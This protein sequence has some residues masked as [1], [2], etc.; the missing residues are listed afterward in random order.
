M[1]TGI[2]DAHNLAWKLAAVLHSNA[3]SPLLSTYHSERKPVAQ[4]NAALSINNWLEAVRVPKALGLDPQAAGLV[5]QLASAAPLPQ[6][7]G[8]WLLESALAAGRGV[9]ASILLLRQGALQEILNSGQS[10]QLQ[11]PKEDLGVV[12]TQG[13]VARGD[14][15]EE[16][17]A[18]KNVSSGS[19]SRGRGLP[20]V[21]STEVGGRL[22]HCN[23]A[24]LEPDG[25]Q[26]QLVRN[27]R[28]TVFEPHGC[29]FVRI[30]AAWCLAEDLPHASL[31]R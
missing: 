1:N 3:A 30:V 22:P 24:I 6:G 8:K 9:A 10:L 31:L 18:G 5:S 23:L 16:Q 29:K 20:Y 28:C 4:A 19:S 15:A 13:A 17:S 2:Q 26:Q 27:R 21:P 11:F 14:A 12:Y 25:Q 7:M